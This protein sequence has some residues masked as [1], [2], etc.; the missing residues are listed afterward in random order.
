MYPSLDMNVVSKINSTLDNNYYQQRKGV[1]T[2]IDN[3]SSANSGGPIKKPS[4]QQFGLGPSSI[5]SMRDKSMLASRPR[6]NNLSAHTIGEF[7]KQRANSGDV[8]GQNSTMLFNSGAF[9]NQ[10]SCF[11]DDPQ[12]QTTG[13]SNNNLTTMPNT[14]N[15][16]YSHNFDPF[17]TGTNFTTLMIPNP[18]SHSKQLLSPMHD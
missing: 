13:K 4:E 14:Q 18:Q 9:V 3:F 6:G 1:T 2:Q 7:N 10:S 17:V 16:F 12:K 8:R 15:N 5:T 11:E